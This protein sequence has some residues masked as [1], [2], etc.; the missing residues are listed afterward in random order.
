MAVFEPLY[1]NEKVEC[2]V[3]MFD[4]ERDVRVEKTDVSFACSYLW[5]PRRAILAPLVNQPRF[6]LFFTISP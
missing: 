5:T 1:Q 3:P 2:H 6:M 4:L